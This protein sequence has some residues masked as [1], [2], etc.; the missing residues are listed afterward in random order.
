MSVLHKNHNPPPPNF[1]VFAICFFI[2]KFCVEQISVTTKD[3]RM[4]LYR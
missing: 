3:M 1:R 4:K 2:L